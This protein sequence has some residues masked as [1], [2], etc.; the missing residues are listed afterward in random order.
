MGRAKY[1]QQ[2]RE[3]FGLLQI[4]RLYICVL[5]IWWWAATVQVE[6][7]PYQIVAYVR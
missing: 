3:L 2:F 5:L 1:L 7:I 4:F 6:N